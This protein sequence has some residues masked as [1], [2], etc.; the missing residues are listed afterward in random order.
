MASGHVNRASRPNTRLHRPIC[1]V[2]KA[3][4]NSEPSTH[5]ALPTRILEARSRWALSGLMRRSRPTGR[6]FDH[7]VSA[8]AQRRRNVEADHPRAL[9]VD[10]R[11][12]LDRPLHR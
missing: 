6:L 3:L 7:L 12:E 11:L 1:Y 8:C 4:A 9:A 10:H 5:G 2:K